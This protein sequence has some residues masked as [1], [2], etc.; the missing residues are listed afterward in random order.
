MYNS[1]GNKYEGEFKNNL[2]DG[3]GIQYFSN[4]NIYKCRWKDD[5]IEGYGI[6]ILSDGF[7]YEGEFKMICLKDMVR[8]MNLVKL[9]VKPNLKMI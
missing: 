9:E 7:R 3:Y 4:G 5:K 2:R 1:N 8:H 6:I